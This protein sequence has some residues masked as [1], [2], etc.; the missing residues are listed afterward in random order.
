MSNAVVVVVD[1]VIFSI[2]PENKSKVKSIERHGTE[3]KQE[4]QKQRIELHG[5]GG[6]GESSEAGNDGKVREGKGGERK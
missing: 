1:D 5:C 2:D 4:K 3:V 6:L